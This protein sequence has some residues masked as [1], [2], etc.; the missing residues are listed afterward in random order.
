MRKKWMA[1]SLSVVL[2]L[3]SLL[4]CS[5][6]TK[7][8]GVNMKY[9][10]AQ[11]EYPKMAPYPDEQSFFNDK[12]GEWDERGFD[13]A[14]DAWQKDK[15]AQQ[16]WAA[17]GYQDGLK[18]F[19]EKTMPLFLKS[20]GE[21][22]VYSPLN[23]YLA[24]AMLAE[25]TDG[26][27]RQQVLDLLC[28]E[29][30][31]TLREKVAALWNVNYCKDGA[32]TS[33]LANSLWLDDEIGYNEKTLERLA[34]TYYASA[35]SGEMGSEEYD[36]ALR[37][38]INAQTG[39]LL[40][41]QAEGLSMDPRCVLALASTIYFQ[42]KWSNEFYNEAEPGIFHG[43]GGDTD[44]EYLKESQAQNYYWSEQ[45]AAV[46]KGLEGSGNM[47]L[48]LPDEGVTP[49]DLLADPDVLSLVNGAGSWE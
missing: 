33:V 45:F 46:A 19:C 2:A 30:I 12:T 3:T 42:A 13:K 9:A 14:Y 4:G 26:E 1:V 17:D 20:E 8:G 47:W 10:M 23:L 25:V 6:Q 27:S 5:Q 48:F 43:A 29:N 41:E 49:E 36:Q 37:D 31:E 35:F 40:K 15:K 38:W 44:C 7:N 16:N 28:V 32:V 22:R 18:E 21:N 39:D 24:L 34:E 11:A